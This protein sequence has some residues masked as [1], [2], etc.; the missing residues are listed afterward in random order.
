MK[1]YRS[2]SLSQ[3]LCVEHWLERQKVQFVAIIISNTHTRTQTQKPSRTRKKSWKNCD[4]GCLFLV[5]WREM[6]H[7]WANGRKKERE[8]KEEAKSGNKVGTTSICHS[9]ELNIH[10]NIYLIFV[11]FRLSWLFFPYV[12]CVTPFPFYLWEMLDCKCITS[13][14]HRR[15]LFERW[16]FSLANR[17]Q[18]GLAL[19]S[20]HSSF[21]HSCIV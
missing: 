11:L 7:I 21:V 17:L 13:V 19:N 12:S 4:F 2:S 20:S 15:E 1:R 10:L 8:R 9:S 14:S 5:K 16:H 18:C 6:Q 3:T